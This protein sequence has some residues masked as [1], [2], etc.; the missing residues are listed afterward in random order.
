[1]KQ[2]VNKLFYGWIIV[3]ACC[4]V[5]ATTMGIIYNT[6]SLFIKP[7]SEDLNFS[8]QAVSALISFLN[9]GLMLASFFAGKIFTKDNIIT[10]MKVAIVVM[11]ITYFCNSFI[12]NIYVFYLTH[13]INGAMESL[14]TT[15]PITFLIHNWFK[16]N[17]GYALGLASMGSGFG[18]AIFNFLAGQFLSRF[19]WRMTYQILSAFILLLAIPCIFFVLK[20]RPADLGLQPYTNDKLKEK[21]QDEVTGYAMK[22]IR[23]MPLFWIFCMIAICLGISMNG[24]YTSVSSHLQDSGYSLVFSANFLSICMFSVAISKVILGKIFDR[25][26][27]RIA[28]CFACLCLF[29]ATVCLLLCRWMIA[30][31]VMALLM[32]FGVIFGAVVFPLSLPLIFGNKEYAKLIGPFSSLISLGGMIGP[33]L[34]GKIYDML[35]SYNL[36]Y[37][38]SLGILTVVMIISWRILP[39][40]KNQF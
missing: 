38:I 32:G 26:G 5:M 16:D 4:V 33:I 34:A 2:K 24:I 39:N 7:I 25:F 21:K 37:Q 10:I 1:M 8:R 22:E 18:G 19:G 3:G 31:I 12:S 20:L 9:L 27:V 14:V 36:A 28:F 6:N 13:I 15:I 29:I 35:G 40:Q 17:V 23:K 30:L 11:I